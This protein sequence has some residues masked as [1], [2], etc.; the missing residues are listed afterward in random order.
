MELSLGKEGQGMKMFS[1]VLGAHYPWLFIWQEV[2]FTQ[3]KPAFQLLPR[4]KESPGLYPNPRAFSH[5][6]F[7]PRAVEGREG[8]RLGGHP[9]AG[10]TEPTPGHNS[11]AMCSASGGILPVPIRIKYL[12]ISSVLVILK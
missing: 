7:S 2:N 4:A 1:F 10:Q 6:I 3:V 5:T 9:A 8:E 11:S 12:S